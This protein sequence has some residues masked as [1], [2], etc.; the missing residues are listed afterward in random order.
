MNRHTGAYGEWSG[1]AEGA[2]ANLLFRK[3]VSDLSHPRPRVI[4][5][6]EIH[7]IAAAD[8][9]ATQNLRWRRR[10]DK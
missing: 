3:A 8:S 6:D 7:A 9:S 10:R 2:A 4:N 5:T 1:T